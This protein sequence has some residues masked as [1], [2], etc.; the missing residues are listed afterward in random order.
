MY[1]LEVSVLGLR[2]GSDLFRSG[3]KDDDGSVWCLDWVLWLFY[4]YPFL[5]KLVLIKLQQLFLIPIRNNKDMKQQVLGNPICWIPRF[6]GCHDTEDFKAKDFTNQQK[7]HS[8]KNLKRNKSVKRRVYIF[9]S[10][11]PTRI[12]LYKWTRSCNER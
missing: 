3:D 2:L 10:I 9:I 11:P 5:D 4:Y 12:Y 8:L 6:Y 1:F 7:L